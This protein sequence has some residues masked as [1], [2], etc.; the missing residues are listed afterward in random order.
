VRSSEWLDSPLRSFGAKP[1]S[2]QNAVLRG[3]CG[4]SRENLAAFGNKRRRSRRLRW[5]K[6]CVPRSDFEE[7]R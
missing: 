6:K 2:F 1:S 5:V 4:L 7:T 3:E